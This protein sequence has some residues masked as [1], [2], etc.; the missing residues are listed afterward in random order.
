V[1]AAKFYATNAYLE[2]TN[3]PIFSISEINWEIRLW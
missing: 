2:M 1:S 3:M